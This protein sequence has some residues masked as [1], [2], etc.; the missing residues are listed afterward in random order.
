MP[1]NNY[2]HYCYL[3][4]LTPH[5]NKWSRS[6]TKRDQWSYN[7]QTMYK[8]ERREIKSSHLVWKCPVKDIRTA[9]SLLWWSA[10]PASAPQPLLSVDSV[11]SIHPLQILLWGD[12]SGRTLASHWSDHN[13]T[14]LSLTKISERTSQP[15]HQ[16]SRAS[17]LNIRN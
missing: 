10:W 15:W 16:F 8:V 3:M 4:S 9:S 17:D 12:E 7:S 14:D 6:H 5:P 11:W 13:N 2:H 1:A